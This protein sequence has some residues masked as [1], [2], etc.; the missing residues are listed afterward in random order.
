MTLT[1]LVGLNALRTLS[2]DAAHMENENKFRGR[3][4][5]LFLLAFWKGA[6]NDRVCCPYKIDPF[7]ERAWSVW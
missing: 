2:F 6:L 1:R 5:K 4:L 3:L 7:S